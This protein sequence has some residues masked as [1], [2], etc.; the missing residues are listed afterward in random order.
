MSRFNLIT[1]LRDILADKLYVYRLRTNSVFTEDSKILSNKRTA[2][3][4]EIYDE[5]VFR[6]LFGTVAKTNFLSVLYILYNIDKA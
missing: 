6:V 4:L 3:K 2:I 5:N 1:L